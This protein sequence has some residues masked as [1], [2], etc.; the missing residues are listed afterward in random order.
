MFSQR[1]SFEQTPNELFGLAQARRRAGV[2]PLDLTPG[3]PT[4]V[5]LA[6]DHHA[7]IDALAVDPA[8]YRP[9]CFGHPLARRALA[10]EWA[11]RG[12]SVPVEQ[13]A[14]TASTS[15]AYAMAFKLFCDPGDAVLI[16]RPGYPLLAE[17]ARFEAI[18]LLDY[19]LA[20]DGAWHIDFTSLE[21][22]LGART[23]AIV[24]VSPNN[25]TGSVLSQEEFA[26]LQRYGLPIISDEVFQAYPIGGHPVHAS[27][28]AEARTG[29]QIVLD[30]LSKYAALPQLKLGWM[31]FFGDAPS[32]GQALGRLE[33]LLDAYLSVG[34][35][36]QLALPALLA[37]G[38]QRRRIVLERLTQ[39]L[40][41]LDVALQESA[42]T[43]LHCDA[44]WY[45]VLRL[46]QVR[47][48]EAWVMDLLRQE[49]VLVA[50]GWFFDFESE[51][52]VVLSLL[53]PPQVFEAGVRRLLRFVE[54]A[55]E[56][57]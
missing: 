6:F 41:H 43:R 26:R 39:N 14:L 28:V 21:A 31:S 17:L 49:N 45:A 27:V 42:I 47:S 44:G 37:L 11:R 8:C 38:E 30:G 34:T 57:D 53:T 54:G 51:P 35:P 52:Y 18:R 29:V 32:V 19:R 33:F 2:P 48:E 7:L 9:E 20:Y 22:G 16:P 55:L 46:P 3:N 24:V 50:P 25:P 5:E 15:E 10:L 4:Q 23:K 1:T 56:R 12:V 36:V 40:T 13:I